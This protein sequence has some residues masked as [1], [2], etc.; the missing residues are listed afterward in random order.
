MM[1]QKTM[2]VIFGLLGAMVLT[3]CSALVQLQDKV[4][5]RFVTHFGNQFPNQLLD[6]GSLIQ[7]PYQAGFSGYDFHGWYRQSNPQSYHVPWDFNENR[8]DFSLTLYARWTPLTYTIEFETSGGDYFNPIEFNLDTQVYLPTPNLLGFTFDGW[9]EDPQTTILFNPNN[10]QAQNYILYAKWLPFPTESLFL[11]GDQMPANFVSLA[12]RKANESLTPIQFF[13]SPCEESCLNLDV[14][15]ASLNDPNG[16]VLFQLPFNGSNTRT[17]MERFAPY[18]VDLTNQSW[19]DQ[20]DVALSFQQ[21][22]YGFPLT[23]RS[24]GLIYNTEII[25]RYNRLSGVT[26]INPDHWFNYENLLKSIVALHAKKADLGIQSVVSLS[27]EMPIDSFFNAYLTMGRS[28]QDQ[29]VL[30]DLELGRSPTF[31]LDE[32][33]NWLKLLVDFSNRSNPFT[34]SITDQL[35][36]FMGQEAVMMPYVPGFDLELR[37]FLARQSFAIAPLGQ[38]SDN[39]STISVNGNASWVFINRFA[40]TTTINFLKELLFEYANDL[41]IRFQVATTVGTIHPFRN[42]VL[43][44][45]NNEFNQTVVEFYEQS[46]TNPYLF[47]RLNNQAKV[48]S[49]RTLHDQWLIGMINRYEFVRQLNLWVKNYP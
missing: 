29:S 46:A 26:P 8:V 48:A 49:L 45:F 44:T 30:L 37:K 31:R 16:P 39:S 47:D 41:T 19:N 10:I 42:D 33:T 35:N 11:I 23:M 4:I 1:K 7:E 27:P 20:T 5:V 15:E 13:S 32:Y 18:M 6:R 34:T 21:K 14:L 43:Q 9:Y 38:F 40:Q 24:D 3:S 12:N 25:D 36:A 28:A 2:S 22:V 17:L